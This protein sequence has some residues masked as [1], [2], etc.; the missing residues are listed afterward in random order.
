MMVV[1]TITAVSYLLIASKIVVPSPGHRKMVSVRVA[2]VQIPTS[3]S[4][5]L[6]IMLGKVGRKI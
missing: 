2:P 4:A 6:V 5:K 3:K 1:P